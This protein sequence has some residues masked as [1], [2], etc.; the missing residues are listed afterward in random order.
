[1]VPNSLLG[2]KLGAEFMPWL[3]KKVYLQAVVQLP[4]DLFQ[5]PLNQKSLLVFQNHGEGAQSRDVL[6]AKLGSLREEKSLVDFNQKLN[7]WYTKK[8]SL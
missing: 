1:M 3:A 8:D 2:G 7:E 6:L 4:N 5:N